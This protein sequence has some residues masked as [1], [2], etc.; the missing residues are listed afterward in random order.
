MKQVAWQVTPAP[1]CRLE[2]ARAVASVLDQLVGAGMGD[3]Q[4]ALDR[5]PAAAIDVDVGSAS[6]PSPPAS[7]RWVKLTLP[8]PSS[9]AHTPPAS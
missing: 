8:L 2:H 3:V 7:G 9:T 5:L 4:L 1:I 6:A